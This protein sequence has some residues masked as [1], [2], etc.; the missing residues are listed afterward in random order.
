MELEQIEQEILTDVS[1]EDLQVAAQTLI[2]IK[3]R[4]L[5]LVEGEGEGEEPEDVEFGV[6]S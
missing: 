3:R 1:D 5:S 6:A 4:L 2:A